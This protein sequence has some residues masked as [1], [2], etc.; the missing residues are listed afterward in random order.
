[1]PYWKLEGVNLCLAS[2]KTFARGGIIFDIMAPRGRSRGMLL[3][4]DLQVVDIGVIDE[5]DYLVKFYLCNKS[6][7]FKWTLVVVYGP[8]QDDQKEKFLAELVHM[9]SHETL[10]LQ[11]GGDF[12]ILRHSAEKT[13]I[14]SMIDGHSFL[15]PTS[16]G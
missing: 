2:L 11:M 6:D 15:T 3:A 14:D 13:M 12:N 16:M 10:P 4:V 8:A 7:S 1:L 9:C 5:G